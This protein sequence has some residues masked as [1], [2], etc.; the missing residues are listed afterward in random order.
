M[1][2][3]AKLR[4]GWADML[5]LAVVIGTSG[6]SLE[7]GLGHESG[8]LATPSGAGDR[9]HAILPRGYARATAV[10]EGTA[11]IDYAAHD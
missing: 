2:L 10:E 5:E 6:S 8:T 9:S 11:L 7:R 1:T 4:E 3:T